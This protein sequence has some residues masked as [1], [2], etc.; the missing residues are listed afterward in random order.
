MAT[1]THLVSESLFGA[2]LALAV[3]AAFSA[4]ATSEAGGTGPW[5]GTQP[6][7]GPTGPGT[8]EERQLAP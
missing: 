8:R 1:H 2:K 3:Q 7:P 4:W 6:H 5:A